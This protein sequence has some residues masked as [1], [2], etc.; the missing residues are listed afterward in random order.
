MNTLLDHEL[1]NNIAVYWSPGLIREDGERE[2]GVPVEMPCHWESVS[3]K[4]IEVEG[5]LVVVSA[6]IFLSSEIKVGGW[7]WLSNVTVFEPSGTALLRAPTIPPKKQK[8]LQVDRI[9]DIDN[10]EAVWRATI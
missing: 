10:D 6:L 9:P 5:K 1:L 8:I 2:I 3:R 4:N 7:L